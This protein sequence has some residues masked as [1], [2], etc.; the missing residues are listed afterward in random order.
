MYDS[1]IFNGDVVN[2]ADIRLPDIRRAFYYGDGIFETM[3]VIE[4]R[5]IFEAYHVE[6]CQRAMI[7]LGLI[8]GSLDLNRIGPS[9]QHLST[10]IGKKTLRI[11]LI[12]FRTGG[13]TYRSESKEYSWMV[14]ADDLEDREFKNYQKGII[15]GRSSSVV[16]DSHILSEFKLLSAAQYVVAAR[17]CDDS[18][19]DDIVICGANGSPAEAISSN[20]YFLIGKV[21]HT[22]RIDSGCVNGVMRTVLTKHIS[23]IGFTVR[24]CVITPEIIDSSTS[25]YLSNAVAG[26]LWV[27]DFNGKSFNKG[28]YEKIIGHLN[29]ISGHL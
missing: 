2:A 22:P 4:G 23:E 27:A 8:S 1:I 9:I 3:R 10:V 18:G 17:E 20:I 14:E 25:M 12:V 29:N 19:W 7:T 13:G 6:R 21:L 11:R 24:P 16:I 15:V 28:P 5:I 26:I